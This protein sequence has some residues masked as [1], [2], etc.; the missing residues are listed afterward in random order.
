MHCIDHYILSAVTIRGSYF[1]PKIVVCIDSIEEARTFS[2]LDANSR[3]CKIV[4]DRRDRAKAV[5]SSYH[6][7]FQF[8][9]VP[10]DLRNELATLQ[11]RMHSILYSSKFQSALVYFEISRAFRPT[12]TIAWRTCYKYWCCFW[13]RKSRSS[14]WAL[15]SSWKR[16]ITYVT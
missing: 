2:A 8:V 10:L 9:Q 4:I 14:W 7:L 11:Q 12:L 6:W 5:F 1:L 16:I 13:M 3:F 15:S